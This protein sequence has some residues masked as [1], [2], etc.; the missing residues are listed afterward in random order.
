MCKVMED[1]RLET[2]KMAI[3]DRNT[4]M[5]MDMIKD[6]KMP[7]ELISQYSKLSLDRVKELATLGQNNLNNDQ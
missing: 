5:A 3:D 6:G 7:L 2:A 4:E 1:M